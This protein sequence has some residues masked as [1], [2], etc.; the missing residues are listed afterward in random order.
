VDAQSA[1]AYR[2][3]IDGWRALE[4]GDLSEA[5]RAIGQSLALRPGDPV[6]R[7][8]QA[9]LL[10]AQKD[11]AAALHVLEAIAAARAATPAT[12]YATACVD[13]ARLLERRGE[14]TRAID[15]YRAARGVFGADRRTKDAAQRAL[16]RLVPAFPSRFDRR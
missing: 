15:L 8:R 6:T 7:Y 2:L 1:A 4:R 16:T 11:D 13:A 9:R 3:S 14:R 12:I 5:E 10:T